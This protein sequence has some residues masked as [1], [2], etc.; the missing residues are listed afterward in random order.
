M[1]LTVGVVCTALWP[2]CSLLLNWDEYRSP[3]TAVAILVMA[4][5][6]PLVLC[7]I[8]RHGIGP[9][10]S[11]T[12]I[13]GSTTLSVLLG[14]QV[15]ASDLG[16]AYWMNSWS[17]ASAVILVFAR[18]VEEP[19]LA[20]LSALGANIAV[21]NLQPDDLQAWHVAP[22]TIGAPVPATVCAIA[23][24]QILRMN[25][26]SSR[27]ARAALQTAERQRAVAAAIH[28][29][30]RLRL[31]L[32]TQ[33]VAPLLDEV[34]TG[35]RDPSDPLLGA[36]CTRLARGLRAALRESR[37]SPF[38]ELLEREMAALHSRGGSLELHDLD[39][40]DDLYEEDRV[41]L[42]EMV[43]EVCKGDGVG[44]VTLTLTGVP[45]KDRAVVVI[46]SDGLPVPQGTAWAAAEEAG[47]T[48]RET[49]TR[50]WLDLEVRRADR[51]RGIQDQSAAR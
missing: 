24:A 4:V 49:T 18:P 14:L 32:W 51:R 43:R 20:A 30:R 31:A 10:T 46:E 2:V 48:T 27:R 15:E 50:W 11:L 17:V 21:S 41:R 9:C 33:T 16:G 38:L 8:G 25:V 12:A 7:R 44:F 47:T 40:G 39:V 6:A 35:R 23:L 1:P 26:R 29:Q 3:G 22:T 42:T 36:E 19:L 13:A 5:A 37:E 45:G 34:A 28:N